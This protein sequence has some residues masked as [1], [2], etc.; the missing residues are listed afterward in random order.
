MM[1]LAISVTAF[2]QQQATPRQLLNIG[3]VRFTENR[4]QIVN[5]P[6][7]PSPDVLYSTASRNTAIYFRNSGISY[8][9]TR[10]G[11]ADNQPPSDRLVSR[12]AGQAVISA[13][14]MDMELL[15]ANPSVRVVPQEELDEQSTYYSPH[16]PEGIA[17]LRNF[18]RIVYHDIYP[19]IDLL[20]YGNEDGLHY[21]FVVRPGGN[22]ADIRL[23]YIGT[24]G[25]RMA[26][27]GTVMASTPLGTVEQRLIN[28]YQAAEPAALQRNTTGHPTPVRG[29]YKLGN[30]GISFTIGSYDR[31]QPLVIAGSLLFSTD[32]G[33]DT[34]SGTSTTIPYEQDRRP[35][36]ANTTIPSRPGMVQTIL[37]RPEGDDGSMTRLSADDSR[38][39]GPS[40]SGIRLANGLSP[41]HS[42][43]NAMRLADS[44]SAEMMA[45]DV[46]P[47]GNGGSQS[48]GSDAT[49]LS[50]AMN[51]MI[52]IKGATEICNGDSTILSAPSGFQSYRWST[53]DTTQEIVVYQSGKYRATVGSNGSYGITETVEIIVHPVP[54][55]V[56]G[57]IGSTEL[58]EGDSVLLTPGKDFISYR[59]SNGATSPLIV[60]REP[61]RFTVS[62]V[63][64]NGCVGRTDTLVV[65]LR[66]K[67]RPTITVEGNLTF[68]TGNSTVLDAGAG[69]H[70]Y[71][72]STGERTQRITVRS[73][74]SYSVRVA[75]EAGCWGEAPPVSVVALP[76]PHFRIAALLPTA[77]CAGDST[78]L[79]ASN[80]FAQY[81]WSTGD[82]TKTITVR[83]QGT[84][85]LTA[86]NAN[87]CG[88]S[89][90]IS[91]LIA[92]DPN[93]TVITNRSPRICAGETV[94]LDAGEG[95]S[96]Y[97][98]STGQRT[99]RIVVSEP[100]L[101][102]VSVIN[103]LG[104]SG[105]SNM[106]KV[107]VLPKPIVTL[108]GALAVCVNSKAT[109]TVPLAMGVNYEWYATGGGATIESG[110]GTNTVVVRWR[111]KGTGR[112]HLLARYPGSA[113]TFSTTMDVAVG[114]ALTPMITADGPTTLCSGRQVRL[115]AGLGYDRYLWS[116]GATTQ[117]II[118]D[119][120]G[121][122]SVTVANEGE[123][124]GTSAPVIVE[125]A[126]L[127]EPSIVALGS[128]TFCG[129]GSVTLDAGPGYTRYLWS[130][131]ATTRQITVD[132]ANTYWVSV[133]TA[134]NC[135]AV[136]P[137]I[138]T[139]V[140]AAPAPK[141]TGPTAVCRNIRATYRTP[142]VPGHRYYW[143]VVG[144][145][146]LT[147]QGLPIATVQWETPGS[148]T[149]ELRQESPDGACVAITQDMIAI[150]DSI[151]PEIEV[152]GSTA[153]CAGGNVT[154]DAGPGYTSYL[155]SNGATTQAITVDRA[156][157]YWVSVRDE[158]GCGGTSRPL[159]VTMKQLASPAVTA[160]GPTEFCEGAS[161]T[162]SA[163]EGFAY[164]RWSNG[165]TMRQITV[166]ATGTY[167]V[168]LVDSTG[169]DAASL[170]MDVIVYP[171]PERP[172]IKVSGNILMAPDAASYGWAL[173]GVPI[174]GE[175]SQQLIARDTG[176]YTVT[177]TNPA[178]CIN[179]S[180]P[181]INRA[182]S[183]HASRTV[184]IDTASSHVGDRFR[185]TMHVHPP[186]EHDDQINGFTAWIRVPA[187]SLFLHHVISPDADHT[188][189]PA[190]AGVEAHD[191]VVIN[192]P[193][194]SPIMTGSR[195]FQMELEG[196]STAVPYN[197]IR[198]DSVM[199][200]DGTIGMATAHGTVLL[201]GCDVGKNFDFGKR[202]HLQS[203][204][205][206]PVSHEAAIAYRA[207]LGSSP[208]VRLIN[209]MGQGVL[210]LSLATGTGETQ[211]M[212]LQLGEV[213]SGI[214]TLE[215]RDGGEISTMPLVI[216]K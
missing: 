49:S 21:E 113:C 95:Y 207:P 8:V 174:P 82:T 73:S 63:D 122:Y 89:A 190:V 140:A 170:P 187:H 127:P 149:L 90:S 55:R 120:A 131:G 93:P 202:A 99:Q 108:N 143:T 138:T 94:V 146:L 83:T 51:P 155:W 66:P 180:A 74:G 151:V 136:S 33:D 43:S 67:P 169:C 216:Q 78:V 97:R 109:Y 45:G 205:P 132:E 29:S 115:D 126:S 61:G 39:E 147:P 173:N 22:A 134:G 195:L 112:V 91:V 57:A 36:S 203:I 179:T 141:I 84:Y 50:L 56:I 41:G 19:A 106:V 25:V 70:E 35:E 60:V 157:S 111:T 144:G 176:A 11:A 168:V 161:V 128:T 142:T 77:F 198:I 133:T 52:T 123:C 23:R 34:P 68:C 184:W 211:E 40:D 30:N 177:I 18:G 86:F 125:Q 28:S 48:S 103:S 76:A 107:E 69:Y 208:V 105:T 20:F 3:A 44:I 121:R 14:R 65:T 37:V 10:A 101:Y 191:L 7:D 139:T 135:S 185:L 152:I 24:D 59:W 81:R 42:I 4:G 26:S 200:A 116:N 183:T 87:G 158:G 54:R 164:Y 162:L 75:N 62:F 104:C 110:N 12:E 2:A 58:C 137:S 167:S 148:G 186:L 153:I 206:N 192:R 96:S 6:G 213:A 117:S 16:F 71:L 199:F 159:A 64:I 13:Y 72:W 114:E 100:G 196:L 46:V 165:S 1:A 9:F 80:D 175:T 27:Q 130:N 129:G 119:R 118:V 212:R 189:D 194:S 98:W 53:G 166:A 145:E 188:G 201:S 47:L 88:S 160:L 193:A 178:G 150:A 124:S 210:V 215:L 209:T 85:T 163:P 5:T 154:L 31:S 102:N 182:T 171:R 17:R 197:T 181:F 79:T 38:P 214:Y 92:P 15:G 32:Y 204:Y 156:A 172:D